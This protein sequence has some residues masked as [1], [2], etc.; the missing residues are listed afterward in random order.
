[1]Y[2]EQRRN[3]IREKY[4]GLKVIHHK[5]ED[6]KLRGNDIRTIVFDELK[7]DTRSSNGKKV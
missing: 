4:L 3:G 2:S 5:K 1:M 6:S 7:E